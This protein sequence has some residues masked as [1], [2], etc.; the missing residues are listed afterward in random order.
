MNEQQRA[1]EALRSMQKYAQVI[2]ELQAMGILRTKN[3]LGDYTEWLVVTTLGLTLVGN[4]NAAYDALDDVGTK[5]Q[6]KGRQP[7]LTNKSTQLGVLRSLDNQ[8][9]DYLVAILFGLDFTPD[10][11]IKAPFS[12]IKQHAR[13]MERVNGYRI[14]LQGTWLNE[15]GVENITSQFAVLAG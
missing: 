8:D 14:H 15:P 4:S 3:I 6:I 9:F 12:V 1:R 10:L 7:T 2:K 11:V 5:Y 13:Y